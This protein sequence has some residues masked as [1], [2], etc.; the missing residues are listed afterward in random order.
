MRN[1]TPHYFETNTTRW[2]PTWVALPDFRPVDLLRFDITDDQ[3][4]IGYRRDA[5]V[6]SIITF[7]AGEHPYRA[8]S[9]R[10]FTAKHLRT[11]FVDGIAETT[12]VIT[13]NRTLEDYIKLH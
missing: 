5:Q 2:G 11:G 1:S 8:D 13:R 7:M 3:V 9:C 12:Y 6:A 4:I 10:V